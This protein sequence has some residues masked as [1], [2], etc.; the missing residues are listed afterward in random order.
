MI[1]AQQFPNLGAFSQ[2]DYPDVPALYHYE[3]GLY[4]ATDGRTIVLGPYFHTDDA[5]DALALH[6]VQRR[7][8]IITRI[9]VGGCSFAVLVLAYL[10]ANLPALQK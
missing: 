10:A 3:P 4:F 6:M 7:Q 1:A 8:R 5:A 2:G 9:V